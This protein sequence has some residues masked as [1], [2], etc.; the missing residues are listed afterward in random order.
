M[1]VKH[2]IKQFIERTTGLTVSKQ[3]NDFNKI[4]S[5]LIKRI[6]PD[7][8]I[9]CGANSGQ[10]GLF[11]KNEFPD[12]RL[13][14]FEPLVSVFEELKQRIIKY[15]QWEVFNIALSS[16]SG[17]SLIQRASN[18]GMSSS[19]NRPILHTR[20]HP[21]ITF[22]EG[23]EVS[24]STLDFFNLNAEKIFLKIDVQGHEDSVLVGAKQTLSSVVMIEIESSFTPLYQSEVAHHALITKLSSLGFVPF[25]YGN[26]HQDSGGRVWQLDTLLVRKDYI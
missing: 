14:S 17:T 6:N 1:S 13:M 22:N 4:R 2:N 18:E 23:A 10:W 5:M 19:L 21:E 11:I 24:V 7:L 25:S 9:D 16:F 12:L 26:V 15:N 3:K 20:V 8:V